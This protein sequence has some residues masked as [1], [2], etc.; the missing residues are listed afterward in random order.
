MAFLV[1]TRNFLSDLLLRRYWLVTVLATVIVLMGLAL[2]LWPLRNADGTFGTHPYGLSTGLENKALDLLFQLR[3]VRHPGRRAKGLNEPIVL[4]AI[5]EASIKASK[6]R[7]QKWPR[8]WYATLV[9]H[10]SKGGAAVIGLDLLLSEEGGTN[11]EDKV[12]THA[13]WARLGTR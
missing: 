3:D 4:I 6:V 10:A 5:D 2:S 11:P 13:H 1:Q 7:L 8:D 12:R 9:D